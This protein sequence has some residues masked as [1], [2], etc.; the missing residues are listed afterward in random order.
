MGTI[1][2]LFRLDEGLVARYPFRE[3]RA[4]PTE[5]RTWDGDCR[6]GRPLLEQDGRVHH[7]IDLSAHLV[8]TATVT[9]LWV[10]CLRAI[11]PL[12]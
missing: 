1:T 7:S 9:A 5:K 2:A 4:M 3:H 8:D 6:G 11:P 12:T 10:E